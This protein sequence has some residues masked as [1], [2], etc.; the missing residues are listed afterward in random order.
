MIEA[1]DHAEKGHD[2]VAG[3]PVDA[4]EDIVF[5]IVDFLHLFETLLSNRLDAEKQHG[6]AGIGAHP[7]QLFIVGNLHGD[8]GGKR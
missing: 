1:D 2:T 3:N 4:L 6:K 5:E 7:E 8:L